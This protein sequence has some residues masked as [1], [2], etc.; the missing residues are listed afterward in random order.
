MLQKIKAIAKNTP[1]YDF[2]KAR[3]QKKMLERWEKNISERKGPLPHILKQYTVKDYASKYGCSTLIETG[4]F[5]GDMVKASL[6]AFA[7]I[8]SIELDHFFYNRATKK[9]SSFPKVKIIQ[10]DSGKML[11]EILK[12]V[13][14]RCIFWLDGHYSAGGTAKG[15]LDTPILMEI[16]S[17]FEHP[18]KDHVILIDDARCFNGTNDYPA[19]DNFIKE[20]YKQRS[21]IKIEVYNDIIRI[22]SAKPV[23]N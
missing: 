7:K 4:T 1:L 8:Y 2:I 11:S 3:K 19:L 13:N 5:E 23:I 20:L 10:G 18:I 17:I 6:N 16:N 15:D 9:F 22:T 14:T 12:E 21:D